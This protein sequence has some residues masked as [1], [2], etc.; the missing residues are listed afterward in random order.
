[1]IVKG[2]LK[3]SGQLASTVPDKVIELYTRNPE[4]LK[5]N[6]L[7]HRSYEWQS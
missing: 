4:I 6:A 3:D 5:K 2:S 1:M 7:L